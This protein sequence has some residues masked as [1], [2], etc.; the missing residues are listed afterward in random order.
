MDRSRRRKTLKIVLGLALSVGL[1]NPLLEA[2]EA[3][4]NPQLSGLEDYLRQAMAANPQLDAFE[5]R[6]D[7][8]M[9]R[10]PQASALPDP[11]FQVTHFVESVQ[12][13]TGPQENI[14]MLSQKIPW[15]GKL[16]SRENAASAEAQAL[17][18]AYQSQQLMLARTVS[19]AFYEYGYMEEAIRITE[20]NLNLLRK[21]E[22][23]V[24]EKVR[25]GDKINALLRLKVEIG[26]IDDRL[27]SLRQKRVGQSARLR[28]LLALPGTDLLPWPEWTAPEMI[29]LD[30]PSLVAAIEANNPDLQMLE[31]KISSAEARR[32]IARLESYPDITLGFNYIQT[33]DPVVNPNT[34]DAGQDPWGFTV[35]VN[36]PIWFD[37]YDAAKAEALANQRS[38]ESEYDNRSNALRAELSASLASL[39][40]ANRRL[41]LYGE[42]LLGLARQAV[43]NSR[44]DYES[45]RIGIL[46]V[47]DSERSLLDLQLLYWRAAAD[48]WQQR[49]TIQALANLP[50]LGTFHATQND[51]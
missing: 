37:K 36:I 35:A 43:E 1:V 39:K 2:D 13:R 47:I 22:P 24:E 41:R 14:F 45:G 16:S 15:F 8:A 4:G 28:E 19:V 9:Q 20:E 42:D 49:I 23:I 38:Y 32:E 12:T 25:G 11:M 44:S 17:W 51:E 29:T 40:D 6:Y 27:Q 33:G 10:I 18:F 26:K 46:D 48:A 7:A 31:R 30:G 21:L 3:P 5:R 50:I 34:P